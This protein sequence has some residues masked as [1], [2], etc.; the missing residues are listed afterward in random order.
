MRMAFSSATSSASATIH[1]KCPK[2]CAATQAAHDGCAE[3]RSMLSR[4]FAIAKVPKWAGYLKSR[5]SDQSW[6]S[7]D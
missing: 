5:G 4:P 6:L 2:M 3:H 1:Q 7:G